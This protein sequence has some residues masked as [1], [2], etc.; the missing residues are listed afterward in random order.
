MHVSQL[1][2]PCLVL[3]TSRLASNISRMKSHLHALDVSLRPHMK[4]SKCAEVGQVIFDGNAGPITVS[5]LREAEFFADAGYRDILYG[6]SI[7][8]HKL[9]R[10]K[11]LMDRGVK[12]SLILDSLDAAARVCGW[13]ATEGAVLTLLIEID[14]DGHRAGLVPD[15]PHVL[16]LAKFLATSE[17]ADFRGFMTH[18][19]E[20]YNCRSVDEIRAH[21][22]L[23]RDAVVS[24][25]QKVRAEGI[26]CP[27]VSV[28]STPTATFAE[29]LDGVTEMRAG[30]F[31]FQDLFQ[32]TLGVCEPENIAVS[33][34]ASVISHKQDQNRLIVDAGGLAL[35]KD[36]ST[37]DGA[38]DYLYG[39]VCDA[40]RGQV[41]DNLIV[42]A[43]N[44]EHGIISTRDGSPIDF[45]AFPIDSKLRILPNHACMTAAAHSQ[46]H[47]VEGD[48]QVGAV[49]QRCNGW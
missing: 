9:A 36:R 20:S 33:V 38:V 22:A 24:C 18:G 32:A 5:T 11:A 4:T 6:V 1:N 16:E 39:L 35:S 40:E 25:A 47:T 34:L 14:C 29:N 30:V 26:D 19:G 17:H 27:V 49:W 41:I 8:P 48:G 23:E 43:A 13:A 37:R 44:Q 21:A 45:A 42:E 28:G 46:Y 2:T 10:V 7:T 12:V 3:D 15:D 31:V